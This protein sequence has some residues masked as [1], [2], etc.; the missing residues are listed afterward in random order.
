[1][2]QILILSIFLPSCLLATAL[3]PELKASQESITPTIS[4]AVAPG[5]NI[6]LSVANSHDVDNKNSADAANNQGQRPPQVIH[7]IITIRKEESLATQLK[8]V[9]VPFAAAGLLNYFP[10]GKLLEIVKNSLS[11]IDTKKIIN[12][13]ATKA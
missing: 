10:F 7:H 5:V 4:T 8:S 11:K 2:K 1:M 12:T 13:V 3:K 6:H 9:A